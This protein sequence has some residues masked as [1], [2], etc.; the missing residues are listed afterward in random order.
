MGEALVLHRAEPCPVP[1]HHLNI[2]S[3]PQ[4]LPSVHG[5]VLTLK[6]QRGNKLGARPWTGAPNSAQSK[7]WK[8]AL[9]EALENVCVFCAAFQEKVI[10]QSDFSDILFVCLF[11]YG[12]SHT[13][14]CSK[15]ILGTALR[16]HLWC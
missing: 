6:Q 4:H 8:G 3:D 13:Q 9:P 16:D 1:E 2:W 7:G 14:Q 5:S 10:F 12:L 15:V 11:V